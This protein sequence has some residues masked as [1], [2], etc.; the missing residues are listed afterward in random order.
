MRFHDSSPGATGKDD[1][2]LVLVNGAEGAKIRAST[3]RVVAG[4]EAQTLDVPGAAPGVDLSYRLTATQINSELEVAIGL[5]RGFLAGRAPL[6]KFV[7]SQ[8]PRLNPQGN[9][10]LATHQGAI[11][12]TALRGSEVF[13][14]AIT[15]TPLKLDGLSVWELTLQAPTGTAPTGTAPALR[16]EFRIELP[17]SSAA[18]GNA[19]ER[20]LAATGLAK[21]A[22]ISRDKEQA[23]EY[24]VLWQQ[25]AA[26]IGEPVGNANL[27]ARGT[28]EL[29]GAKPS[30]DQPARQRAP[31]MAGQQML[32]A[33]VD[34][35]GQL[36]GWA[37]FPDPRI[38]RAEV[39]NERGELQNYRV[40]RPETRF[41]ALL[42]ASEVE[43]LRFFTTQPDQNVPLR[44]IGATW[45]PRL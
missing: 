33:A 32:V 26:T 21:S 24:Q 13:R 16:A 3:P 43:E 37:L 15:Q 18:S 5:S 31:E 29:L 23:V 44:E 30:N 6:W 28:F 39:P 9:L 40:T 4:G 1:L 45:I 11:V 12:W 14:W 35:W 38:L 42:V 27:L 34:R 19:V 17:P 7:G 10:L 36:R 2:K 20:A 25:G 41:A 8:A 22:G